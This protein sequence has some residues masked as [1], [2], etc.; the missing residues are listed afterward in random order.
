MKN[1]YK[2]VRNYLEAI[3]TFPW[4]LEEL[5]L[6][7]VVKQYP[8]LNISPSACFWQIQEYCASL[9]ELC[10][11]QWIS[12]G[13]NGRL[14]IRFGQGCLGKQRKVD[15]NIILNLPPSFPLLKNHFT[16]IHQLPPAVWFLL[17]LYFK[18]LK[19]IK[20]EG[21]NA[22]KNSKFHSIFQ[23]YSSAVV[24]SILSICWLI[25]AKIKNEYNIQ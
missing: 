3:T 2:I 22:W 11:S 23:N 9:L 8:S 7:W 16:L 24:A 20:M 14:W 5:S 25:Y 6:S 15:H 1:K 19:S 13:K 4:I 18:N 10:Y 17:F 21:C 12:K